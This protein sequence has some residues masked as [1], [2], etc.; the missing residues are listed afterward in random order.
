MNIVGATH[1]A[2]GNTT[3]A[4]GIPVGYRPASDTTSS[5]AY[6][7]TTTV[8]FLTPTARADGA[9]DLLYIAA[10]ASVINPTGCPNF[11][12]SWVV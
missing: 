11:S 1:S 7:P 4:G 5:L 2:A 6:K 3:S 12:M 8:Y 9:I 10:D